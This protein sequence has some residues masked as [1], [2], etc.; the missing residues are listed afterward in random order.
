MA[1][2]YIYFLKSNITQKIY[3]GQATGVLNAPINSKHRMYQ[4]YVKAINNDLS[5]ASIS[6]FQDAVETKD[7]ELYIYYRS[8]FGVPKKKTQYLKDR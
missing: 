7:I 1:D 6:V 2:G 5:D 8:P 4:H 3:V